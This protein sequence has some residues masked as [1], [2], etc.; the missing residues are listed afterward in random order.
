[1]QLKFKQALLCDSH[2]CLSG[3][4]KL[5]AATLVCSSGV[6]NDAL[7]CDRASLPTPP[8][9]FLWYFY[10]YTCCRVIHASRRP[11]A[12]RQESHN[13]SVCCCT[14]PFGTIHYHPPS[15]A[16]ISPFPRSNI[17]D[18][19]FVVGAP[20]PPID[21]SLTKKSPGASL[22]GSNGNAAHNGLRPIF[23]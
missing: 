6:C 20:D 12:R 1:M 22:R 14:R 17:V 9:V 21:N 23:K 7:C 8:P 15:L 16:V 11:E 19:E 3:T 5:A 13:R 10:W 4:L 2:S 18:S